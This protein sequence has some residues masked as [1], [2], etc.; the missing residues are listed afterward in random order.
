M[1]PSYLVQRPGRLTLGN[2][3]E[4]KPEKKFVGKNRDE[5]LKNR[6]ILFRAFQKQSARSVQQNGQANLH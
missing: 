4:E 5:F 1:S 2:I 6:G 3:H